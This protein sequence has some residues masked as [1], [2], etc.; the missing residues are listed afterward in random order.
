MNFTVTG[1][2]TALFATWI[3]IEELGLL[4]QE[5]GQEYVSN[6]VEE[7]IIGYSGDTP[8]EDY[9]R[10]NNTKILIHEATF[11]DDHEGLNSKE[12]IHSKLYEVMEMASS[13]S[14][15]KLVLS[16]FSTR[17]SEEQIDERIKSLIQHFK[18][19]IPVYRISPGKAHRDILSQVPL[20]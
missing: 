11:L 6:Q 8:V 1:Y 2:S 19:K 13:I 5:H 9:E 14:I 15:E 20:N 17:Y 16:H 4:V 18:L 10:W 3:F 7:K 12:H